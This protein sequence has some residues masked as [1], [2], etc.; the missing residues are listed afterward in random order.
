MKC[1][2]PDV[3]QS[4]W[5]YLWFRESE[6]LPQSDEHFFLWKAEITDSGKYYCQGERDTVVGKVH[7]LQSLPVEVH[8]DG[9]TPVSCSCYS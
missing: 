2:I 3:Y 8:V 4:A 7:T 5:R 9:K 1:T 6:Q